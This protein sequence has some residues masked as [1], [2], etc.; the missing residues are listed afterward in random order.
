MRWPWQ[1]KKQQMIDISRR[2]APGKI[3]LALSG[4]AARGAAHLGVLEVLAREGFRPDFVVGVSAGSVVG[5]LYCAGLPL[6]AVQ[7][8]ARALQWS[9]VGRITRP[10]LGFFDVSRL[11]SYMDELLEGR[12]FDQLPIPFATVAVD[13]LSG[14]IVVQREGSVSRA[15][16]TSCALPG[17]FTP[18]EDGDRLLVD[19]GL[20]N[21]LPVS[22]V[23]DMGADYVIAVDLTG[24]KG[25]RHRP[26]NMLEMWGLTFYTLISLTHGEAELADCLIQP[27]V[28]RSSFVDFSQTEALIEEGRKAAEAAIPQLRRDLRLEEGDA[29]APT[30]PS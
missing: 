2:K 24:V 23:R 28:A 17:A 26:R 21:N 1:K 18:V 5:A 11:E 7:E 10:R 16:R 25:K 14:Q 22:V 20:V 6:D 27:D 19:G 29:S 12:T 30:S 15:V 3:G 8:Q 4:G 13:I 9:K